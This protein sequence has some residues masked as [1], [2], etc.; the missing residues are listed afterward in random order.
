[1]E[2]TFSHM[3]RIMSNMTKKLEEE[4]HGWT[5]TSDNTWAVGYLIVAIL[6]ALLWAN[7]PA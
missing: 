7:V 6:L 5:W 3:G 2:E 4:R 1:M